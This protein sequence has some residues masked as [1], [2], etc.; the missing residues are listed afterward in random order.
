MDYYSS[1]KRNESELA[2][3]RWMSL[4][5]VIQSELSQKE[6]NK[7]HILMHRYMESRKRVLINLLAW[8]IAGTG[9]WRAAVCG[10]TPRWTRLMWLSS[11]SK[12]VCRA[13]REM[14][15][16]RTDLWTQRGKDGGDALTGQHWH[17]HTP[18]CDTASRWEALH[19]QGAQPG[20]LRWPEG[21]VGGGTEP[22]EEGDTCT[23]AADPRCCVTQTNTTL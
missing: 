7:Y 8:R 1:I 6:K 4:E 23:L 12:P 17:I 2:A 20:A 10:V 22:Q 15:T 21:V 16:C 14:Q 13:G 19:G 9:A 18:E 11:S 5:S 3:V